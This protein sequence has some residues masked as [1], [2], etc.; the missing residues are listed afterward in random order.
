MQLLVKCYWVSLSTEWL[1]KE[2]LHILCGSLCQTLH[3]LDLLAPSQMVARI[4]NGRDSNM[5][6]GARKEGCRRSWLSMMWSE[7]VPRRTIIPEQ[8]KKKKMN[9]VLSLKIMLGKELQRNGTLL[10]FLLIWICV[11][12]IEGIKSTLL[13]REMEV[14]MTINQSSETILPWWDSP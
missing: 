7:T 8:S 6:N 3:H 2:I 9:R 10:S 12:F 1:R 5:I 14:L 4:G 11:C 13:L